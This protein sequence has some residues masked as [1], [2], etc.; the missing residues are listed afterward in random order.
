MRLNGTSPSSA[1]VASRLYGT[2]SRRDSMG[3]EDM[4]SF[5]DQDDAYLGNQVSV[6]Y[7]SWIV[8]TTYV[9]GFNWAN[10]LRIT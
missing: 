8:H 6:D 3:S 9:S 4:I 7:V 2:R 1:A 5:S 10:K